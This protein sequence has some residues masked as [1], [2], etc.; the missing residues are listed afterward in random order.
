LFKTPATGISRPWPLSLLANQFRTQVFGKLLDTLEFVTD[1]LREFSL[2]D[3]TYLCL[4]GLSQR[5]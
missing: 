3:L 1:L 4:H 5:S 2:H